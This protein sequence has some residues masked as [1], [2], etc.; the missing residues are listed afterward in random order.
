MTDALTITRLAVNIFKNKYYNNQYIPSINKLYL[1]NFIKQGYFGGITEVYIPHGKNL[2]YID[3]NSLYP[4]AALNPMPGN[5]SYYI[6]SFDNKGLDL[7]NLFG[8][9]YAKVKTNNIYI[10][11]LPIY[12][13]NRV[14]FPE[15]EF[16]GI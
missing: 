11:L 4:Y 7:D 9:F 8:F 14:I 5:D 12:K 2:V 15:G 3:V 6:E 13:D 10:G 16:N 1:F